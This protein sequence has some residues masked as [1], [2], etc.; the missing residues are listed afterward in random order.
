MARPKGSKNKPKD[1][2]E[3]RKTKGK[4]R[5]DLTGHNSGILPE[6]VILHHDL[7]MTR[8]QAKIQELMDQVKKIRKEHERD[9]KNDG[10]DLALLKAR[11]KVR[12]LT[13]GKQV[14]DHNRQVAYDRAIGVD[15]G[16]QMNFIDIMQADNSEQAIL[17]RA[18]E[19]GVKDGMLAKDRDRDTYDITTP[20]GQEY[21][22]GY[23][24][25]QDKNKAALLATMTGTKAK[26][27][28]PQEESAATEG[29]VP[30]E[31]PPEDEPDMQPVVDI[32]SRR[33]APPPPAA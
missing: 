26:V 12:E 25:G 31:D 18:H 17:A 19:A 27:G 6:G 8:D 32:A 23:Q 10:I 5:Q 22:R 29:H 1:G 4:V 16:K 30:D 13:K 21:E 20:A 24:A 33:R 15:L 28:E 9:A 11:R 2:A 3:P 14:E 7:R